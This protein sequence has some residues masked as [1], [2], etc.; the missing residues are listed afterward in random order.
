MKEADPPELPKCCPAGR[1]ET[2]RFRA[3]L[4]TVATGLSDLADFVAVE[5]G[6]PVVL[7]DLHEPKGIGNGGS[8]LVSNPEKETIGKLPLRLSCCIELRAPFFKFP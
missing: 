7:E 6:E 3:H 4:N 2:G 5:G 1:V 8:S